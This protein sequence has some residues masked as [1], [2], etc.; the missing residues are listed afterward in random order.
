MNDIYQH[1]SYYTFGELVQ[2]IYQGTPFLVSFPIEQKVTVTFVR[3]SKNK[4]TIPKEKTKVL[5]MIALWEQITE[6]CVSGTFV[7]HEPLPIGKGYASS[8][9]NLVATLR[10]LNEAYHISM[11][12]KEIANLLCSIEPTDSV[13]S[14]ELLLFEQQSGRIIH[15]LGKTFPFTIIGIDEGGMIDTK[16]IYKQKYRYSTTAIKEMEWMYNA[17]NQGMI[18]HDLQLIYKVTRTS[19][20]INQD[21]LQKKYFSFFYERA[22]HY[23]IGLV[24]A[25]S[26]S[27][28]G[29]LTTQDDV[30]IKRMMR[31]IELKTGKK[32]SLYTLPQPFIV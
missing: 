28:I 9:A 8:S 2:G 11:N 31:E 26:G 27:L 13:F 6:K 32:G 29:L 1:F 25:H 23:N 14:K 20:Y 21:V 18:H 24:V 4:I 17:I 19:A 7:Y 16:E 22:T 30:R 10:C 5:Q 12:E 3:D 15:R